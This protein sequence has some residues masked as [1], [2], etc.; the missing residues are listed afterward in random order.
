[1]SDIT[2]QNRSE[3]P[4]TKS[5]LKATGIALAIAAL[6]L[7]T[8]V[9]PAEYG[10]DL[11]G[12]GTRLGLTA[13]SAE[14][15]EEAVQPEPIAPAE[16]SPATEESVSALTAVWKNAAAYRSDAMS[17]TLQPN[18]GA[19]IKARMRTGERFVFSW[20]AENGVVNFDMH[21]E[22][23][24]AKNDEF[25]SYWKGKAQ[26]SG[27]GAFVAPFDGTHGWYW[28]NRGQSPVTVRV[29]TSGY[30]EQLFRP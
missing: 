17:L 19:E 26:A 13:M 24:D 22:A 16:P 7:A 6:T 27:H 15:P 20:V 3:L 14:L 29:R 28:R 11:T 8:V 2:Q 1:M 23:F 9:L 18:E 25:T 4:S 21:G 10:I 30:Y 5:L 12:L